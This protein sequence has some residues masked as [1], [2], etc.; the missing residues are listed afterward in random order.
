[1]CLPAQA[2]QKH[3]H[4]HH[5]KNSHNVDTIAVQQPKGSINDAINNVQNLGPGVENT[6][7]QAETTI[8]NFFNDTRSKFEQAMANLSSYLPINVD[9]ALN[10]SHE[11]DPVRYNRPYYH[12]ISLILAA[13]LIVL[14]LVFAFLGEWLVVC[15][16]GCSAYCYR[17]SVHW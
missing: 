17:R 13:V 8:T 3:H 6:I 4:Q 14:G 16:P 15:A 2:K 10:K 12:T 9:Y 11:C 1:M 5:H 7:G